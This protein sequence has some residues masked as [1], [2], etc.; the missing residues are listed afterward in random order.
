[1]KR[2]GLW[3]C[4]FAL[5]GVFIAASSAYADKGKA[6]LLRVSYFEPRDAVAW[7]SFG[8]TIGTIIDETVMIGIGSDLFY[9][10]YTKD[11]QVAEEDSESGTT[12]ATYETE[13]EYHTVIL[14][15]MFEL[16]VQIPIVWKCSFFGH[17][18]IGTEILWNREQYYATNVKES[19]FYFGFAWQLGVGLSL[20][21]SQSTALFAQVYYKN[22]KVKR[23][24]EDI[25]E[26]L[27]V[28][29]QVNLSG[30]GG[31]VGILLGPL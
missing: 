20:K 21:L 24:R 28:Y 25:I 29:E 17:G 13:I 3:F 11:T 16:M 1:M 26:D 15:I 22:S 12:V 9:K 8:G 6:Y 19:R 2:I 4:T 7:F 31:R 23:S 27:P 14:P 5:I 30:I 18:G 10:N